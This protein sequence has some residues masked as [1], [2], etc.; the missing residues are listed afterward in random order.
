MQHVFA[1]PLLIVLVA[2][3]VALPVHAQQGDAAHVSVRYEVTTQIERKLP[4][5]LA[6]F[7]DR[8]P[9]S[10]TVYRR[11]RYDGAQAVSDDAPQEAAPGDAPASNVLVQRASMGVA[12][13]D[14]STGEVLKAT[15]FMDR[16]FL[17]A[18]RVAE[19]EWALTQEVAEFLGFPAYKATAT[20]N[21]KSVEAWFTPAVP[22]PVGP[23]TYGGLPGL[24]LVLTEDGGRRTF[25]AQD[26]SRE[27]LGDVLE[28]PTEGERMT[29]AAYDA[30]VREKVEQLKAN[31][32]PGRIFIPAN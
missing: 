25:V 16:P 9:T 18:D 6:R 21:G 12:H 17:V 26:V 20:I 4:P 15:T 29:A 2:L 22:A 19:A 14:V 24:I 27:P 1:M 30:L 32:Q 31:R 10:H 7:A 3:L 8:M 5:E 28:R 13:V 11:V 23:E